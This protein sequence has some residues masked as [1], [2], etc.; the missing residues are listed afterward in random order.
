MTKD[1]SNS[2]EHRVAMETRAVTCGISALWKMRLAN[3]TADEVLKSEGDLY[4]AKGTLDA[5][6]EDVRAAN[7]KREYVHPLAAE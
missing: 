4:A 3:D 1:P 2:A 7:D 6:I 5:L